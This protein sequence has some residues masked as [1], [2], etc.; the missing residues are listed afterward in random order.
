MNEESAEQWLDQS[1][2]ASQRWPRTNRNRGVAVSGERSMTGL[3][4]DY[5]VR[6]DFPRRLESAAAVADSF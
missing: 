4:Y 6:F 1:A 3:E 5:N 2:R